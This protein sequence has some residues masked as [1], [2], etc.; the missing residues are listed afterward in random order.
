MVHHMDGYNADQNQNIDSPDL[1]LTRI[2]CG[3]IKDRSLNSSDEILHTTSSHNSSP[4][5]GHNA[6]STCKWNVL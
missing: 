2:L 3:W 5:L 1:G 4:I 6:F